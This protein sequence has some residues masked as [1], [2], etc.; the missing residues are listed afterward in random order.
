MDVSPD[1]KP[2]NC[3]TTLRKKLL[4]LFDSGSDTISISYRKKGIGSKRSL[5][6]TVIAVCGLLSFMVIFGLLKSDTSVSRYQALEIEQTLTIPAYTIFLS[7]L[8]SQSQPLIRIMDGNY[9][10]IENLTFATNTTC[11]QH[12]TSAQL[13]SL[14]GGTYKYLRCNPNP[15]ELVLSSDLTANKYINIDESNLASK[16]PY[17]IYLTRD[18]NIPNYTPMNNPVYSRDTVNT[19]YFVLPIIKIYSQTT[20]EEV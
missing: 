7:E 9:N 2:E 1:E 19:Y 13:A 18:H 5:I 20:S 16:N 4:Y 12:L 6:I 15:I 3:L 17:L 14:T 10:I 8:A 11:S